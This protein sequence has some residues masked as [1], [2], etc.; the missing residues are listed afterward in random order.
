MLK[1]GQDRP[2]KRPTWAVTCVEMILDLEA[3]IN[4]VCRMNIEACRPRRALNTAIS[5]LD[6]HTEQLGLAGTA[7]AESHV[8]LQL[9]LN[10][11]RIVLSTNA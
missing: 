11:M 2:Y 9:S 10:L 8:V 7:H 6:V 5:V 1:C 4:L 3:W